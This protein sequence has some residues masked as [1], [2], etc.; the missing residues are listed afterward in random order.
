MLSVF[1]WVVYTNIWIAFSVVSIIVYG[2]QIDLFDISYEYI[3]IAFFATLFAYNFQRI[4]KSGTKNPNASERHIWI[5]NHLGTV[6][7]ITILSLFITV[8]LS[9]MYLPFNVILIAV[10]LSFLVLFYAGNQWLKFSLRRIS[11]FSF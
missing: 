9:L 7:F 5:D 3:Y 11:Y 10:I 1:K 8:L 6:K 4:E 2:A